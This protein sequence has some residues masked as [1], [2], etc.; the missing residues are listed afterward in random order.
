[1]VTCSEM[2]NIY[3]NPAWPAL[4][5][6]APRSDQALLCQPQARGPPTTT[7]HVRSPLPMRVAHT[8]AYGAAEHA[9]KHYDVEETFC[10]QAD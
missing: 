9:G 1:M 10:V 2:K 5:I 7:R 3:F 6:R 4:I 8:R